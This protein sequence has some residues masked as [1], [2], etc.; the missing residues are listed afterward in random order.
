[1]KRSLFALALAAALPLSAQAADDG[2]S[3]TYVEADYIN[4]DV[5]DLD[6]MDG[7][8]VRGNVGFAEHWYGTA[9]LSRVSRG[10]I[11][12]GYTVPVDVDFEQDTVGIGFHTAIGTKA[13]F[14]AELAYASDSFEVE[15]NSVGSADDRF[16]GYRA[17][18]GIRTLMGS[19]FEGEF[20]AHYTDLSDVDA[21]FGGEI[22]GIF[23]INETWGVLAGWQSD[24]LG[25][26][27]VDQ[28]KLG[29]RA[30]F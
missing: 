19:R 21:G 12:L 23:H 27:N 28:W 8:A 6:N 18:A 3:F 7:F 2:V 30:S 9:S 14:L 24:D 26:D 15:N 29:V 13:Q 22:N 10:D 11:D 4:A 1:M 25:D 5:G 17:T 16:N 20:K